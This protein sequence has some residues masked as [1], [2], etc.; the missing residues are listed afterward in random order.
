MRRP[1]CFFVLVLA[2]L[3]PA[4]A[5]LVAAASDERPS[6]MKGSRAFVDCA[7]SVV[8]DDRRP[9]GDPAV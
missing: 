8:V 7:K 6:G 5:V 4:L 1:P 2:V 3:S 9:V